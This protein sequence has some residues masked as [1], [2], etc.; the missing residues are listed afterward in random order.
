M[1]IALPDVAEITTRSTGQIRSKRELTIVDESQT[2]VDV[3]LWGNKTQRMDDVDALQMPVILI[4][5]ER[6]TKSKSLIN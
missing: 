3:V 4:E 1:L 2:T 6:C 5:S